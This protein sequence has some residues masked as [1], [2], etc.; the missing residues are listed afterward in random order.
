MNRDDEIQD[1]FRCWILSDGP[2]PQGD[3]SSDALDAIEANIEKSRES[4]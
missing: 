1:D 2:I 3:L 4:F